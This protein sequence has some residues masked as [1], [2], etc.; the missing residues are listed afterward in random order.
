[1]ARNT[2]E[3]PREN[4]DYNRDAYMIGDSLSVGMRYGVNVA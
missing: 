3:T 2:I 4:L 1:M